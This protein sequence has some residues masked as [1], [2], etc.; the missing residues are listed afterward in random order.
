[1]SIPTSLNMYRGEKI[2]LPLWQNKNSFLGAAGPGGADKTDSADGTS[3][4]GADNVNDGA[5]YSGVDY[6]DKADVGDYG[7]NADV[8][9]D[10]G[11]DY[12]SADGAG[13][14]EPTDAGSDYA[15]AAVDDKSAAVPPPPI[16]NATDHAAGNGTEE[17]TNGQKVKAFKEAAKNGT[18][19]EVTFV[20]QD[21]LQI[22]AVTGKAADEAAG[23]SDYSDETVAGADYSAAAGKAKLA[24]AKGRKGDGKKSAKP[25][26]KEDDK[27]K[28]MLQDESKGH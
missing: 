14:A 13:S 27:L 6:G 17:A 26:E 7:D 25:K 9:A 28:K 10:A 5:G 1:M 22:H 11:S 12:A 2:C 19:S 24:K 23:G 8:V 3:P 16:G 21:E 15:D 18:Q 20:G 4:G